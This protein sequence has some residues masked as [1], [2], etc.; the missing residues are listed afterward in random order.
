LTVTGART[1]PQGLFQAV[2]V[3][4]GTTTVRFRYL[5]PGEWW[6]VPM[7]VVAWLGMVASLVV[8]WRRRFL[9][10]NDVRH[11]APVSE[12]SDETR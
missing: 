6:A 1:G 7:F 5:P 9:G 4:A 8:S 12:L 3:P 11:S 2:A 10:R